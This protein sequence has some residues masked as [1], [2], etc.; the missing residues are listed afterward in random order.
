MSTRLFDQARIVL[1]LWI[2]HL[3]DDVQHFRAVPQYYHF[4]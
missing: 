4:P 1:L 3:F 2:T